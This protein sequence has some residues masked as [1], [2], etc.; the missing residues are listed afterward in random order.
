MFCCVTSAIMPFLNCSSTLTWC[1]L[2]RHLGLVLCNIV[3][4]GSYIFIAE[5][6]YQTNLNIKQRNRLSL[7]THSCTSVESGK[8]VCYVGHTC[9]HAPLQTFLLLPNIYNM[10]PSSSINQ[11]Y[12]TYFQGPTRKTT[13]TNS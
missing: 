2:R 5:N 8:R 7:P 11:V 3:L 9:G 13:L 6:P 4:V 12:N 1:K 10:Y